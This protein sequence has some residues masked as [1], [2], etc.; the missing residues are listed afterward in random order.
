MRTFIA[1]L[2]FTSLVATAASAGAL[3]RPTFLSNHPARD[4]WRVDWLSNGS[5]AVSVAPA[6]RLAIHPVFMQDDTQPI[7]AAAIE[8]SDAYLKRAKIHRFASYA[9]L[10]LFA[11]ELALGASIYNGVEHGDW[12]KGA[13]GVVATA[14]VGLFGVN[15]VTGAWNLFGE[16]WNDQG[17]GL[18]LLHGLLMMA[19]D[20]GFVA[21]AMSTPSERRGFTFQTDQATHRNLAIASVGLGT[22]GYLVM[23]FGNH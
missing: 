11:A 14:I 22:T 1:V 19:A 9:T 5:D 3:D 10:P 20:A 6:G 16:S 15:T 4:V 18:R 8:H 2:C 17:R 7:H 13:H 21:T 23:L 12:R